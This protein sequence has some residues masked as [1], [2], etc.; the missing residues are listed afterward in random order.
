M[1]DTSARKKYALLLRQFASGRMDNF[2]FMKH[3]EEIS[4]TDAFIKVLPSVTWYLYDDFRSHRLA[5]KW[6]LD[7][8]RR[9]AVACIVLFL[10]SDPEYK[11]LPPLDLQDSALRKILNFFTFGLVRRS[12]HDEAL[13]RQDRWFEDH[14]WP[15]AAQSDF[16]E[17]RR[18]PRLLCGA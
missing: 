8:A 5:G 1:V 17:A 12:A 14:L 9:K 11:D 4:S 2:T 18:H 6:R 16:D 13:I 3:E 10:L 7:Q 15:F